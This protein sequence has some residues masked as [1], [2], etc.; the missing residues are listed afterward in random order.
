MRCLDHGPHRRDVGA[1]D[2]VDVH[3][4]AHLAAVL[5]DLRRLAALERRAEHRGDA[6]VRRVPGHPRAV[7]VVV[8]QRDGRRIRLAH[9]RRGVVLLGELAGGVRAARVEPGVLVDERPRQG[10]PA[11]RAVVLE[12][13]GVEGRA[14]R[15][16]PAPGRRARRTRSDP[17]RRR[18][19]TRPARAG[20]RRPR[21]WWRAAPRCRGR[22]GRRTPGR[23]ATVT[24]APTTAAWW[25]TTSTPCEQVRPRRRRRGRRAGGCPS[26]GVAEPWA[27]SSI[28]STRTTSSPARLERRGRSRRR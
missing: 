22:C 11:G 2:V 4:V 10:G 21:A 23:S 3:E 8:P 15:A 6:G 16:A 20:R 12:V 28:R 19:S 7:D 26:G 1:G 24:P 14:S 25:Q 5:V 9:P 27:L 17:R 18:P 13:A